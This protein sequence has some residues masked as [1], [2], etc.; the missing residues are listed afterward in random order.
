MSIFRACPHFAEEKFSQ[1]ANMRKQMAAGVPIFEAEFFIPFIFC[2]F[3][4]SLG[5][6]SSLFQPD[7]HVFLVTSG[8][9]SYSLISFFF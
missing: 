9:K 6:I 1:V 2:P 8:L 5:I 7:F 3:F 4:I